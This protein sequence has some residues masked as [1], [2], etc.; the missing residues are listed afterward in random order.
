MGGHPAGPARRAAP[1]RAALLRCA[2]AAVLCL[3]C[4]RPVA[5]RGAAARSASSSSGGSSAGG[6]SSAVIVG[7]LTALQDTSP[8]ALQGAAKVTAAAATVL[9]GLSLRCAGAYRT[10]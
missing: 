3:A 4:A 7:E 5:G 1:R 2:I 8:L 9:G 6:G 10:R